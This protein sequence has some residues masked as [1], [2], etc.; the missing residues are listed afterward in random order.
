M[1]KKLHQRKS[2]KEPITL[3]NFN[4]ESL[5]DFIKHL[6]SS[7]QA[8]NIKQLYTS[9]V[10]YRYLQ[11]QTPLNFQK[12]KT[13]FKDTLYRINAY[14]P[15]SITGSLMYGGRYNI[16]GSQSHKLINIRPFSALYF[17]T[18]LQC[19]IDE[20]THGTPFMPQ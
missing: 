10:F 6:V 4:T 2:T 1:K 16:G 7:E 14:S 19:A 13:S 11:K 3:H 18:D 5:I 12:F 15:T 20:Y 9:L 17:S 8:R